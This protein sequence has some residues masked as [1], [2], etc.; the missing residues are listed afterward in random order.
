MIVTLEHQSWNNIGEN[1][2]RASQAF[3]GIRVAASLAEKDTD[4]DLI[5]ESFD[6]FGG[7]CGQKMLANMDE[8]EILNCVKAMRKII[9]DS[10]K[11]LIDLDDMNGVIPAFLTVFKEYPVERPLVMKT[12]NEF[13]FAG[14]NGIVWTFIDEI[15]KQGAPLW[16]EMQIRA[17]GDKGAQSLISDLGVAKNQECFSCLLALDEEY[18]LQNGQT[19]EQARTKVINWLNNIDTGASHYTVKEAGAGE[20]VITV[21]SL[22]GAEPGT[23]RKVI[24]AFMQALSEHPEIADLLKD[25]PSSTV[26]TELCPAMLFGDSGW[27]DDV[28]SFIIE[29][30]CDDPKIKITHIETGLSEKAHNFEEIIN[31]SKEKCS[32]AF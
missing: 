1:G 21:S 5:K 22:P 16:I 30:Q 26:V 13:I 12:D 10:G 25:E 9:V 6:K 28:K 18:A 32:C 19:I 17:V 20:D 3:N 23:C 4:I 24:S 7:K 8:Q 27:D 15:A 11:T 14:Q 31:D 29:W 2:R